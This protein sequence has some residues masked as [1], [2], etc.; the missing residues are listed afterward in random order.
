[1][2]NNFENGLYLVFGTAALMA[3]IE[4]AWIEVEPVVRDY[5]NDVPTLEEIPMEADISR[6]GQ[7]IMVYFPL[8]DQTNSY[9]LTKK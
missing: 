3:A 5:F 9:D 6:S 1:M 8:E 7:S 2:A 4:I